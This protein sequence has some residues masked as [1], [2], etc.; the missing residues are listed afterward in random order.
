MLITN[1]M[2]INASHAITMLAR[3][4]RLILKEYPS[5]KKRPS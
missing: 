3:T 1:S 4:L 2:Q 5:F